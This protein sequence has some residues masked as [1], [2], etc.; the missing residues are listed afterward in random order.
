MRTVRVD[1]TISQ[2]LIDNK[3]FKGQ[4]GLHTLS[5]CMNSTGILSLNGYITQLLMWEVPFVVTYEGEH[6]LSG[7]ARR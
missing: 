3:H 1:A 4:A 2:S 5:F 6:D 7:F